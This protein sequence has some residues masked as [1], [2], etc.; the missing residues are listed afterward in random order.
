MDRVLRNS[1]KSCILA[2]GNTHESVSMKELSEFDNLF[3]LTSYFTTEEICKEFLAQQRWGGDVV[4]PICGKNHCKQRFD[5]RY[6]CDRCKHNFSVISGTIFENTKV[7]LRKWFIAMYLISS[8][9]KG[10]SSHQLSRDI[11]VSQ[12]TAWYMLQKIRTLY[13]QDDAT[14]LSGIVECDEVYIGGKEK[15]KHKSMR[16]HH[17]RKVAALRPKRL[18]SE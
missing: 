7:S 12:K 14:A 2:Y 6:R 13:K 11:D 1:K 8:H 4:C 17:A 3:S 18:F 16:A 15:W 10:V 5:G 9:K